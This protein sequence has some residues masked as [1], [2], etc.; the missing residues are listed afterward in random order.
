MSPKNKGANSLPVIAS[1]AK[2]PRGRI[3][4]PLGCFVARAPRNDGWGVGNPIDSVVIGRRLSPSPAEF[5]RES[6]DFV[7]SA[8]V[9]EGEARSA[10]HEWATFD[11][12][13]IG[14][15]PERS[16]K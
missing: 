8:P 6:S 16:P 14:E 1:A 2:Q 3:T 13:I 5:R 4:R 11:S 7:T 9:E 15:F 10:P 12:A